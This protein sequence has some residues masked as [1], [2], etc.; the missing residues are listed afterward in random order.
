MRALLDVNVLIAL[1]DHDHA[2]HRLAYE[3]LDR[4]IDQGWASCPL[5]QNGMLRVMSQSSYTNNQSLQNLV[6]RL[7]HFTATKHHVFWP[8]DISL[9]DEAFIDADKLLSPR[10]LTDAYLLTLAVK[11]GGRLI[12]LDKR[13]PLNSVKGAKALNL[14][15]L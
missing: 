9:L 10:Q 5:T 14:I 4:H 13:I 2:H 1:H 15:S 7:R 8:D 3:W 12:T 6:K 11:H